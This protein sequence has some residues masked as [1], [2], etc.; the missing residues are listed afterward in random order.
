[1]GE[2]APDTCWMQSWRLVG[3]RTNHGKGNICWQRVGW[4]VMVVGLGRD[5]R[6]CAST[7]HQKEAEPISPPSPP[8]P[9]FS[10]HLR[11]SINIGIGDLAVNIRF[12]VSVY[13][14][15]FGTSR[16][17]AGGNCEVF[18]RGSDLVEA[19]L[20]ILLLVFSPFL[21]I[22]PSPFPHV[23]PCSISFPAPIDRNTD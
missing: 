17:L 7:D 21:I 10:F 18:F 4:P 9:F 2:A 16:Q 22:T 13:F 15:M 23:V 8:S 20:P 19:F 14:C 5:F 6:R 11:Q 3:V 1:M 12:F